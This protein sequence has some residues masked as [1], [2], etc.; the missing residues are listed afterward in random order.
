MTEQPPQPVSV[1]AIPYELRIGVTGHRELADEAAVRQ[2]VEHLLEQIYETLGD[3]SADPYGGRAAPA[4]R[5][6]LA[7]W[8]LAKLVSLV[9]RDV[10]V[11]PRRTP[12]EKRTPIEWTVVSPLAVGA[13]RIVAEAVLENGSIDGKRRLEVLLPFAQEEYEKDF[14]ERD[15]TGAPRMGPALKSFRQLLAR[16]DRTSVVA[17]IDQRGSAELRAT[18]NDAYLTVGR[19]VVDACE[20]LIAVWDGEREPRSV[21]TSGI[22]EYA[23]ARGAH[24]FWIDANNPAAPAQRLVPVAEASPGPRTEA[25]PETARDLSRGFHQL[26]AFNRDPGFDSISVQEEVAE[27]TKRL[28]QIAKET[29]LPTDCIEPLIDTIL[30]QQVRADELAKRYQTLYTATATWLYRLAAIAVT[31]PV[32]QVLFFPHQPW[33]IV[34][35]VLALL[36]IL[37]LLDIGRSE[38]WHEKWLQDR[39]LAERLRIALFASALNVSDA[40]HDLSLE[41]MVDYYGRIG[42][43]TN[44]VVTRLMREASA[45]RCDLESIEP[46]KKFLVKAWIEHQLEYHDD[47]SSEQ[48]HQTHGAHRIGLVLF[49]VTLIAASMHALGVGHAEDLTTL[50]IWV[51]VGFALAALSIALPAWGVAVHAVDSMLERERMAARS[52]GMARILRYEVMRDIENATSFEALRETVGRA[53]ELMS[54]ENYEWLTALAFHKLHRPG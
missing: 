7:R 54:R 22:V 15:E 51:G 28:L 24:V 44:N 29:R 50:T 1:S 30:P 35:E 11:A 48:E 53:A 13:D 8:W 39:H 20:I 6:R 43:W 32:L 49:V 14:S 18:R 40:E 26:A 33:I 16:A 12:D 52:T 41:P 3:A 5:S 17:E 2:A 27:E 21:G 10:P 47:K 46:I 9:W 4:S 38:A 31:V 36:V 34:F 42:G 23:L 19:K 45:N 25:M 37:V